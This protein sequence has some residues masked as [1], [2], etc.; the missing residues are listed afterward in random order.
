MVYNEIRNLG[1]FC[2]P[3]KQNEQSLREAEVFAF[4]AEPPNLFGR[5]SGE[6]KKSP[7]GFAYFV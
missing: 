5:R 4:G 3:D 2:R 7:K 6:S 1:S